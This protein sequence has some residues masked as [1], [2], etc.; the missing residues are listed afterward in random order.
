[1]ATVTVRVGKVAAAR[2]SV[3]ESSQGWDQSFSKRKARIERKPWML[4]RI[5]WLKSQAAVYATTT[6]VTARQVR[7]TDDWWSAN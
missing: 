1:M 3:T 7:T 5:R 2:R 6:L 4:I